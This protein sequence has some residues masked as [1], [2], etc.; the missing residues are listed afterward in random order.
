M[1]LRFHRSV[2]LLPGV[3]LNLS[4][5]GVSA[6]FGRRG[7]WLTVGPKGARAT[8]GIPGTGLSYTEQSAWARPKV[9]VAPSPAPE[10]GIEVAE[11]EPVEIDIPP[12]REPTQPD[13]SASDDESANAEGDPRL[14]PIV[15]AIAA[16]VALAS[17]LWALLV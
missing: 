16:A 13:N 6:S 5:S 2:R 4:K 8:V 7:A 11:L 15:L 3:R 17:V 14:V 10:A 9:P 12:A 1:G